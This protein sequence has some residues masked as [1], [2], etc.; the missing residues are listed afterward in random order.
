[1]FT[2]PVLWFVLRRI[3]SQSASVSWCSIKLG[4]KIL[5][6]KSKMFTKCLVGG[7]GVEPFRLSDTWD[8]S[9]VLAHHTF[10]TLTNRDWKT[11]KR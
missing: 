4:K 1:M 10:V 2:V 8:V 6:A 9:Y 7:C 11:C 3:N 5:F